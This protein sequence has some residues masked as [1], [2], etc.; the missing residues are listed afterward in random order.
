VTPS[1]LLIGT[2]TSGRTA[3]GLYTVRIDEA[4]G[5]ETVACTPLADPSFL[6]LHVPLAQG[7]AVGELP[8]RNG[9]MTRVAIE[10]GSART[11][12]LETVS[13]DGRLPCH[14]ALTHDAR[15][16]WVA[17]YGS[18][19]V[20]VFRL[21]ADGSFTA[22]PEVLRH[23]GRSV[24]AKRQLAP[25][26][27]CVAMHPNGRDIHVTDLGTD[28]IE[29]YRHGIGGRIERLE[30]T[31]VTPGSGPRHLR[32]DRDGRHAFLSNE[33]D[34]TLDAF[35]VRADGR[36]VHRTRVSTLPPDFA[37]RS[38]ASE[39]ALSPDA[40]LAYVGNRGHDSIACIPLEGAAQDTV[41]VSTRGAHPRHFALAPD[42]R[43]LAVA[44][45]DGGNLVVYALDERGVP[46]ADAYTAA[47]LPDPAFVAWL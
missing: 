43:R 29:H 8:D 38:Y 24:H 33:I 30:G 3:E 28:R 17:C 36:L 11:H 16:L 45:R 12:A 2:Y 20:S 7:Y 15:H 19:S 39:I 4:G 23:T 44:N 40:R 25:H 42:G 47:A 9:T 18:G 46:R 13:V 6:A 35:D 32:F 31:A 21:A 26:A 27:H 5:I 37:G 10:H 22:P 41:W 34:N 14:A 1:A